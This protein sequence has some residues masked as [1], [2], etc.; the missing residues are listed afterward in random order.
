MERDARV[1]RRRS[2]IARL[3]VMTVG[4]MIGVVLVPAAAHAAAQL[5]VPTDFPT[6]QAALDAAAG[7]DTV[8]VEPGVYPENLDFHQKDVRVESTGGATATTIDVPGGVGI[9]IGPAGGFLG[10][11]VNGA[12]DP[13]GASMTVIGSGTLIQGNI[14]NGNPEQRGTFGVGINGNVASPV[15][16]RNVFRNYSCDTQFGAGVISFI[17]VSSPQVTNNL[18]EHNP[19]SAITMV[20]PVDASPKF[21]NNTIVDN[22]YG[23]RVDARVETAGQIYRNNIVVGNDIGLLVDFGAESRNPTWD[24]NLVFGNGSNYTGIADQ[25]GL[26]GNLSLDPQFVNAAQDDYHL[27]PS[28]PAVDTGTNEGAPAVDFDGNP[29]PFDGDG[30]GIA[31]TDVGAYESQTAYQIPPPAN[32]DFTDASPVASLPFNATVDLRAATTQASEPVPSCVALQHTVW[33]SFTATTTESLRAIVDDYGAGVGVYIGTSLTNLS[34]VGCNYALLPAFVRTQPNTT[35]YFQVGAWCCGVRP[36]T[37]QLAVAPNPV[38]D[39]SYAPMDPSIYDTVQFQDASSDPAGGTLASQVWSFGDGGT[40]TGCCPTHRYARDGDYT[41]GLTVTTADGRSASTSQVVP[42]RTHDVAITQIAV[43]NSARVGQT[44]AVNV[45]LRNTHYP[46]TVRVDLAKSSLDGYQQI[47]WLTQ[48]VPV[49]PP[50]GN[51]T[52]FAF[53]YTITQ[54]DKTDG[55]INFKAVATLFDYRDARPGDNELI[56]PT[57]KIT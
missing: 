4:V 26:A 14:F 18:F 41:V 21:I 32:D 34:Q 30:D 50:G 27:Q 46:E 6:I 55:R 48:P 24:H 38:A 5:R 23:M 19:C 39:F 25:T 9:T 49:R 16:D 42:V 53:S 31:T 28:S 17:N 56:S 3:C 54:A 35:Y 20:L 44:I 45:Y 1:R 52:R 22:Q 43:P 57:V 29:R 7:G 36:V 13:A 11:T 37:F 33:Y 47:G 10:F 40:A 15:I 51:T 12:L 8:L 2:L